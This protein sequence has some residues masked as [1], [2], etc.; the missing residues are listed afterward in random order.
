MKQQVARTLGRSLYGTRGV[1]AIPE[2]DIVV[3]AIAPHR[4]TVTVGLDDINLLYSSSLGV[5]TGTDNAVTR[6]VVAV[7]GGG[8]DVGAY[9]THVAALTTLGLDA[10]VAVIAPQFVNDLDV[11]EWN[12]EAEATDVFFW[13]R[14]DTSYSIMGDSSSTASYPRA[15]QKNSMFLT[16]A[17]IAQ[18]LITYPN[19]A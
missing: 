6:L 16:D 17:L 9:N 3:D 15:F 5:L 13:D 1:G 14:L 2:E 7:H 18:A 10:E 8:R 12:L 11:S 4:F 19:V